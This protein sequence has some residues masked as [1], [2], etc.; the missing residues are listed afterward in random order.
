MVLTCERH[1]LSP[2]IMLSGATRTDEWQYDDDGKDT[3]TC[4]NLPAW[5]GS[6][7]WGHNS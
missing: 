6:K 4:Y 3:G 7:L 2:T 5:H 1:L